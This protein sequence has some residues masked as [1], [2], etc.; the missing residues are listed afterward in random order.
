MLLKYY[1][2][3]EIFI[4]VITSIKK[5]NNSRTNYLTVMIYVKSKL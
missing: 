2:E 4:E 3:H 5:K 1:N